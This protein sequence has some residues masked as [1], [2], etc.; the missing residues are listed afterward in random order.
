MKKVKI[1]TRMV[2][3]IRESCMKMIHATTEIW[4]KMKESAV[5]PWGYSFV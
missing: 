5:R 3:G 4:L 1:G 2:K